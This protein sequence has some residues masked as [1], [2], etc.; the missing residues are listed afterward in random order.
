M[1]RRTGEALLKF[2]FKWLLHREPSDSQGRTLTFDAIIW[3]F[4]QQQP[5]PIPAHLLHII[6]SIRV[7][8][9]VPGDIPLKLKAINFPN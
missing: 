1:C 3:Q 8:G 4:R 2:A 9:N 6:D 7:I 5:S